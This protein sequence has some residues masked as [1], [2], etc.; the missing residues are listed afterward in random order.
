MDPDSYDLSYLSTSA[1]HCLFD[2]YLPPNKGNDP[3]ISM[4]FFLNFIM[5]II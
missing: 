2:N 1:L 3:L 5:K 4:K